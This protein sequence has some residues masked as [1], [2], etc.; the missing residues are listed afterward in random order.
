M[1][2]DKN[3]IIIFYQ[4][5]KF[6]SAFKFQPM[7]TELFFLGHSK[8]YSG[9]QRSEIACIDLSRRRGNGAARIVSVP[10]VGTAQRFSSSEKK[11]LYACPEVPNQ[12]S[13]TADKT[14]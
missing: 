12:T 3:M 9:W 14:T 7:I 13:N 11:I 5:S 8:D 10:T 4:M 2:N 6:W 1:I